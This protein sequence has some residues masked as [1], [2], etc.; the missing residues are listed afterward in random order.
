MLAILVESYPSITAPQLMDASGF[1]FNP[2]RAL[3][4]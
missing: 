1:C 2:Q 3:G 4:E